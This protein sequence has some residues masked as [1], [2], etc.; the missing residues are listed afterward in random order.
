LLRGGFGLSKEL[1]PI[2]AGG[3]TTGENDDM[4]EPEHN[5]GC[6]RCVTNSVIVEVWDRQ[7]D[8]L[9]RWLAATHPELANDPART[10]WGVL[11]ERLEAEEGK[12][13]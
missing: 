2:P 3:E 12:K 9:N 1:V 4:N 6:V 11:C 5:C 7:W 10:P 13:P 8:A